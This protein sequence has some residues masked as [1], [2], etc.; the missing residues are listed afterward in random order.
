MTEVIVTGDDTDGG[1]LGESA[2]RDAFVAAGAAGAHSANAEQHAQAATEAAS[3]TIAASI[4][5]EEAAAGANDAAMVASSAESTIG[6]MLAAH[7]TAMQEHTA[8]ITALLAE[9]QQSNKPAEP[10]PAPEKPKPDREPRSGKKKFRDR[11]FGN[12]R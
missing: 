10:P 3:A 7:T 8:T 6:E 5:V 2:E 1:D 11:Y 12:G 4:A 9:M